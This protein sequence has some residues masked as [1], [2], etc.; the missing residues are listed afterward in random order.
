[1]RIQWNGLGCMKGFIIIEYRSMPENSLFGRSF[2]RAFE[3]AQRK[4]EI[5]LCL[6]PSMW[7]LP[8]KAFSA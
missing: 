5:E 4:G 6:I 1:M 8:A 3:G 2:C 7:L